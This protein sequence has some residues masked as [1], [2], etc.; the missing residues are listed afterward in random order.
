MDMASSLYHDHLAQLV[1]SGAVKQADLDEAVRHVLRVKLALGLLY[2][3]FVDEQGAGNALFQPASLTLAETAAE[4]SLVLLKNAA[5]EG[6]KPLLPL[7]KDIRNLA[8]IGPLADD[9][10]N[11]PGTAKGTPPRI[12]LAAALADRVG[13]SHLVRA[14]GV[15]VI[16]GTDEEIAAAVVAAKKAGVV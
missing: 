15:E 4:R 7:S 8:L 6:G 2:L 13:E 14:K 5:T 9:P 12:S 3:P 16:A 10:P 11:A 1:S